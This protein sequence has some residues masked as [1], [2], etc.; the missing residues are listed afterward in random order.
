VTLAHAALVAFVPTRDLAVARTFYGT[1]LGLHL[2]EENEFAIVY[3]A[4]GTQLRITLVDHLDPAEFTILGWQVNDIAQQIAVLRA[5]GV[6]FTR[7][8]AMQQDADGVWTAPGGTQVAWFKDHDGNTLSL[9]QP[10]SS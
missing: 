5:A 6:R 3:E 7:Y 9:Q 1:V 10:P 2:I 4:N 8:D